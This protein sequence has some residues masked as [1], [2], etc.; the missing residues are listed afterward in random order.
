MIKSCL[1]A[2]NIPA[3]AQVD[4]ANTPEVGQSQAIYG[5][6]HKFYDRLCFTSTIRRGNAL[7]WVGRNTFDKNRLISPGDRQIEFQDY[8]DKCQKRKA[9]LLTLVV[10]IYETVIQTRT[11]EVKRDAQSMNYLYNYVPSQILF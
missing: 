8:E 1:N 10:E 7:Y 3:N 2:D 9:L 6:C 11:V 5:K 4:V